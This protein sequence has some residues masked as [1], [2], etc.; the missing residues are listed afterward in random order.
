MNA[1]T[2]L[3]LIAASHA[4][5]VL[6]LGL[7]A[8]LLRDRTSTSHLVQDLFT[9]LM[10]YTA[11]LWVPVW[12]AYQALGYLVIDPLRLS[13]KWG[14]LRYGEDDEAVKDSRHRFKGRAMRK[15]APGVFVGTY[16]HKRGKTPDGEYGTTVN[17]LFEV[18]NPKVGFTVVRLGRTV[19]DPPEP[20]V[21]DKHAMTPVG[22][23]VGP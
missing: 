18:G 14:A 13:F 2:I 6:A 11:L 10:A 5:Y 12:L 8:L 20:I 22:T 21:P 1:S 23:E 16:T 4:A 3:L 7:R 9:G 17:R 15:V 19:A